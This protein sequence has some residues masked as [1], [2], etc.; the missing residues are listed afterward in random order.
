MISESQISAFDREGF[1]LIPNPFS[2]DAMLQLERRQNEIEPI[3]EQTE[4]PD[5]TNAMACQF[6]MAGESFL[7][8]V[9]NPELIAMAQQLL[10]CDDV[11][12]GACGMGDS[13]SI[14]SRSDARQQVY[15]HSDG[16][17]ERKQVSIRIAF[18][19]HDKPNAPL[20]ILPGSHK[21]SEEKIAEILR[22]NE[23]ESGNFIEGESNLFY[24]M[25]EQEIELILS[26]ETALV[27]TPSCWHATGLK[28]G[29]GRRRT[30][31]WNYLPIGSNNR[32]C[33]AAEYIFGEELQKWSEF[34]RAL[35]GL[36]A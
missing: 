36:G 18:D 25:C 26:P 20:R 17:P 24:A 23:R 6:L 32:D 30:M 12:V 27:W 21:Q 33:V 22:Q 31:A 8:L 28:T 14:V 16:G 2:E 9:E 19:L 4:W 3:W 35:W 15:W 34:R 29:F 1:F 10:Q 11:V 13:L 5:G 7:E